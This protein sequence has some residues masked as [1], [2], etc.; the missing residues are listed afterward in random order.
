MKTTV[1]YR[2][3]KFL[4]NMPAGLSAPCRVG[5]VLLFTAA[6]AAFGA[7]PNAAPARDGAGAAQNLHEPRRATINPGRVKL[8]LSEKGQW[9]GFY[10]SW[11]KGKSLF[12]RGGFIITAVVGGKRQVLSPGFS[13]DPAYPVTNR[14]LGQNYSEGCR[15][16][17]RWPAPHPDD[18]KDGLV[19]EDPLDGVDNDNDGRIDEDFCAM[20]DDMAVLDCLLGSRGPVRLEVHE[21]C[22]GWSLQHIDDLAVISMT[23]RNAGGEPVADVRLGA[24]FLVEGPR[25][26][27]QRSIAGSN[28]QEFSETRVLVCTDEWGAGFAMAF[29][30]NYDKKEN[31]W[32]F[33]GIEDGLPL[34]ALLDERIEKEKLMDG[35]SAAKSAFGNERIAEGQ[36]R[37]IYGVTPG[38]GTLE[39]GAEMK[40]SVALMA[41]QKPEQMENTII[42]A[43]KTYIGDGEHRFLPPPMAAA[44]KFMWGSY[45]ARPQADA[46]RRSDGSP[47]KEWLITI[48]NA[49]AE[50]LDPAHI[51]LLSN[52]SLRDVEVIDFS[53][54]DLHMVYRGDMPGALLDDMDRLSIRGRLDS[55]D[56]FEV[57]LR[58]LGPAER[59]GTGMKAGLDAERFWNRPGK[60]D[61]K[62]L[63]ISPNP[64]H[65]TTS[66]MY[67]IPP[68]VA[69]E[70]D[71]MI[72]SGEPL[73]T[74]LK[75]YNVRGRL[76]RVLNEDLL[77]P[78]RYGAGWSGTDE[79]GGPAAS[80]VYYLKLQIGK[81]HI[82][83]RL[84]LLK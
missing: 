28:N 32:L 29:F 39:A 41:A 5:A 57:L 84:I 50:G 53:G 54:G 76:V 22:F 55:G 21:E 4:V 20:G 44:R 51:T 52:M 56:I 15:G 64:F 43:H 59:G 67:E 46:A 17:S 80:G 27:S 70:N 34:P 58:P 78:G 7:L 19:D 38:L 66:I 11:M 49:R 71:N 31:S 24:Y 14:F 48:D 72:R 16:G 8:V 77:G 61:E 65:E 25:S 47:K 74:S 6:A 33:G 82:T 37:I 10:P 63:E 60:L 2:L 13:E 68:E 18:D 81:K 26:C 23:I 30:D 35:S 62:L 75:I 73:D 42:D 79:N 69:D 45:S 36:K 40:I 3:K 1:S 12:E 83:K 9:L